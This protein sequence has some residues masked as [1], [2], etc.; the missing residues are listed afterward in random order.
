MKIGPFYVRFNSMK[1]N[2]QHIQYVLDVGAYRGAFTNTV[3]AVWPS[4]ITWQIEADDRQLEHNSKAIIALVGDHEKEAVDF[5]TL[6]VTKNTTGSSIF[7]ELTPYYNPTSMVVLKKPMT[8]I[9]KLDEI[10]NFYGDWKNYGMLKLDIQ[11]AELLALDGATKFLERR[12][13]KYI[14]VECSV[15]QYNAGS[16]KIL[17][18]MNYMEHLGYEMQDVFDMSRSDTESLIQIDV[19]FVKINKP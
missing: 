9:D 18:V 12:Q 8:T 14:L 6:P 17:R 2:G 5:Y 19:L 10:H 4:A 15:A 13:P 16:P 11:G 3:H 7:K 1:R